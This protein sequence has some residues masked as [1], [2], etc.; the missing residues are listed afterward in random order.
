MLMHHALP[1]RAFQY[2]IN[3]HRKAS[4][5]PSADPMELS[6][7]FLSRAADARTDEC[8]DRRPEPIDWARACGQLGAHQRVEHR[9]P[10][11]R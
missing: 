5:V 8:D 10:R 2:D 4:P 9:H 1:K 11:H 6:V 3:S 7:G